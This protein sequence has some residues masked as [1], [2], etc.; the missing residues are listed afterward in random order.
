MTQRRDDAGSGGCEG[1]RRYV[2]SKVPPVGPNRVRACGREQSG[3]MDAYFGERRWTRS[4]G[5]NQARVT[6]REMERESEVKGV[7]G[8]M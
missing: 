1:A 3:W 4:D 5:W 7:V 6:K 8:W 2:K